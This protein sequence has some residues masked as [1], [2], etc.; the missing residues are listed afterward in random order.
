MSKHVLCTNCATF[1]AEMLSKVIESKA[2]LPLWSDTKSE[3]TWEKI[4]TY[5]KESEFDYQ[6]STFIWNLYQIQSHKI[7]ILS[8]FICISLNF[9]K[10]I[11][12]IQIKSEWMAGLQKCVCVCVCEGVAHPQVGAVR[13]LYSRSRLVSYNALENPGNL[14]I[15]IWWG[16][17]KMSI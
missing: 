12:M 6:N 4:W 14:E 2:D 1:L 3:W 16:S 15:W 5:R 7:W 13:F 17:N 8:Q 10:K 9:M 11:W